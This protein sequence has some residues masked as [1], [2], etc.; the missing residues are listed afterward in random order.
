MIMHKFTAPCDTLTCVFLFFFPL[1]EPSAQPRRRPP[2][3]NRQLSDGGGEGPDDHR[4]S[5]PSPPR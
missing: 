5:T 1:T 2:R 4:S 3:H